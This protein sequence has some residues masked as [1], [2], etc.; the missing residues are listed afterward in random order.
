MIIYLIRHGKTRGNLFGRYIGVTDES[1]VEEGKRE[2]EGLSFP[3][4]DILYVSS[5]KRTKETAGIL[6]PGKNFRVRKGFDECNF[7]IFENKNYKEL[8]D[9]REYQAWVDSGGTLPFPEGE[10]REEF[11]ERNVRTFCEAVD[12]LLKERAKTAAFVI[13]GGT[14]MSV[15]GQFAFP[16]KPFYQWQVKNGQ[17]FFVN[18][19]EK[20]WKSGDRKLTDI[21]SIP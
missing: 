9:N 17:G 7:G 11:T 4:P 16:E 8:S 19:H 20:A 10:S 14:I 13:H 5:L 3:A 6:F 2:L 15:M 1:L 18:L 12:E 21:R